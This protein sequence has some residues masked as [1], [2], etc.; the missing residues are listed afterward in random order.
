M[1]FTMSKGNSAPR[2]GL[3]ARFVD[4][5]NHYVCYRQAGGTSA[6][7]VARVVNG[8]EKI[9]KAVRIPNPNRGQSFTIGCQ[10]SGNT[11]T[12][13]I[14]EKRVTAVDES[15]TTGATGFLMGPTR[16]PSAPI[17]GDDFQVVVR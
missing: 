1:R 4:D 2:F 9:L 8:V 10:V 15:L 14:G 12:A 16:G 17:G 7:R 11:I 5:E 6:L 3:Y 13:W